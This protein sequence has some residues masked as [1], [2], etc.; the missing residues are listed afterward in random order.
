M[1][2]D[3]VLAKVDEVWTKALDA[4]YEESRA[5]IG[6]DMSRDFFDALRRH[7]HYATTVGLQ[8]DLLK[9]AQEHKLRGWPININ[10]RKGMFCTVTLR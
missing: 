1:T 2:D 5:V 3:E 4:H 10:R 6:W 8:I 7:P 9:A